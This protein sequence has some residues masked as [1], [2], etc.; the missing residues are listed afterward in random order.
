MPEKVF[1][2]NPTITVQDVD[3]K[4][5]TDK[6]ISHQRTANK[7]F[8]NLVFEKPNGVRYRVIAYTSDVDDALEVA[9]GKLY[10]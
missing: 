4:V 10:S 6:Y 5:Y 9:R 1:D 3:E 2:E 7:Q 8:C